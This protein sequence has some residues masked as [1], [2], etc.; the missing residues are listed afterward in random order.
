[1]GL[2]NGKL[3][4]SA[5]DFVLGQKKKKKSPWGLFVI[6]PKMD[7]SIADYCEVRRTKYP[8]WDKNA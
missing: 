3:K 6:K 5:R 4:I 2:L 8:K 7:R 1:M